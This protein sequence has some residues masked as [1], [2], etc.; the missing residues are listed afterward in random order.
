VK[1]L[2]G[3]PRQFRRLQHIIELESN[4]GRTGETA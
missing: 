2:R 4:A 3:S 1:P